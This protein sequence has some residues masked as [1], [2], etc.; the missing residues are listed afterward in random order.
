[1]C[2]LKNCVANTVEFA[3]QEHRNSVDQE[4]KSSLTR[5]NLFAA[6]TVLASGIGTLA[7]GT[8]RAQAGPGGTVGGFRVEPSEA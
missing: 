1:M 5:R 6:A 3:M 7:L 4:R 2:R 8:G